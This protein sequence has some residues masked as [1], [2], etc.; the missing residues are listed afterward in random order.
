MF[1]RQLKGCR[2]FKASQS[3]HSWK[4]SSG[5]KSRMFTILGVRIPLSAP[6]A[7]FPQEGKPSTTVY[8]EQLRGSSLEPK[9]SQSHQSLVQ[10]AGI[11]KVSRP[12]CSTQSPGGM[13]NTCFLS[14]MDLFG[15][16]PIWSP[17]DSGFCNSIE[18]LT[19]CGGLVPA[20]RQIPTQSLAPSRAG[21]GRRQEE[22]EQESW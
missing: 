19:Q 20:S 16:F 2:E 3:C 21:H 6:G 14:V 12:V 9:A 15:F 4:L 7:S 18:Y 13:R 5:S 10:M 8:H 11:N 1:H 22:Q 17:L